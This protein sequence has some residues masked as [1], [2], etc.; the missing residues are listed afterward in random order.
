MYDGTYQR[1]KKAVT[2]VSLMVKQQQQ[3]Q[4]SS[5]FQGCRAMQVGFKGA[6]RTYKI[7][8]FNF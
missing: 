1:P 6:V 3:Q 8:D 7:L 2:G 4:N 5:I